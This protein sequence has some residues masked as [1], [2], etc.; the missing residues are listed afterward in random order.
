MSAVDAM[1]HKEFRFSSD[2]NW[3]AV[4]WRGD[5]IN[6]VRLIRLSDRH[7]I[8]VPGCSY[9][10]GGQRLAID[11]RSGILFSGA[12]IGPASPPTNW[13]PDVL[14]GIAA[15]SSYFRGS[16]MIRMTTL[17]IVSLRGGRREC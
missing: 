12:T 4:G 17:S 13:K 1:G 10:F 3:G 14:S 16:R 2:G 8:D 15:I 5:E 6:E 7:S 11:A 9:D